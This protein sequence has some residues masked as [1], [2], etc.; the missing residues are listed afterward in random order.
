MSADEVRDD[1]LKAFACVHPDDYDQWLR[2]NAES[3]AKRAAFLGE[4]RIVVRGEIRWIRAESTPRSM[5]DGSTI[6]EGVL[7]DVTDQRRAEEALQ[8]SEERY[9]LVAEITQESWWEE[10]PASGWISNSKRFC[11]MLGLDDSMASYPLEDFLARIHPD[12]VERVQNAFLHAIREGSDFKET[13]RIRHVDGHYIWVEDRARVM[14]RDAEGVPI[15]V[16]GALTDITARRQMEI[17]LEESEENFRRLFDDAPD[18]YFILH[19]ED[20]CVLACN[21]ATERLMRGSWQQVIGMSPQQLSPP[22]QPDGRPS[23]KAAADMLRQILEKGYHRFEWMLRRFDGSDFWAEVTATVGQYHERDVLYVSVRE[24]GEIIA[25]KQAAEAASIAKSQ[26]LSVMSH[27]LR[28][29]LTAIMGMFQLIEM[30]NASDRVRQ[31]AAKG[32]NSSDHL[33]KVINDI[34]DFSS[35]EAGRLAVASTPFQLRA[36][37][38]EVVQLAQARRRVSVD[39]NVS[40]DAALQTLE[41]I[42][43]ALR[44]K[45]VLINLVGNAVKFT[46]VGSVTLSVNRAGGS[47]NTPVLEFAV[48]DTG[49]GMTPDQQ[50]RLFQPFTQVDMS[51]A[52]S[53]GG[54]GLGLAI[55]QRLVSLLGGEPITVASQRDHGSRFSFR[56]ALPVAGEAAAS[57]ASPGRALRAPVVE[58]LAG[59][60]LLVVEDEDTT[61]FMLRLLLEA[62]GAVVEE[63]EDGAKGVTAALASAAP[64]DMVLMDMQMSDKDGLE[65]T[66]ELR[67][68]GYVR[69]ILALT[70]N[71]SSRDRDACLAAGMNDYIS[72]PVK[73]DDLVEVLQRSRPPAQSA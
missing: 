41:F 51:D 53:F 32:L 30:A 33:L 55:S 21:R 31:F 38:E 20:L 66:R 61:R 23:D 69:P 3:V 5:P 7:I 24:I 60:R 36:L 48:S 10:N 58:R 19:Q 44:L 49:I 15:R 64:F 40:L 63:A 27:E 28:T 67:A 6:W 37:L 22:L 72:K 65:A 73:I 13:Y 2:K 16:L 47:P 25:A 26:F 39:L 9:R 42:G 70:A 8:E 29:P 14:R 45:Q 46:A 1:P 43:D 35:I 4:T 50:S 71:A 62:E 57:V 12:E 52:R 59:Y 68:R 54:T 18:A 17:A 56:L 11:R 34:L